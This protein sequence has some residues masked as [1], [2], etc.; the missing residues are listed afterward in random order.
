MGK[1]DTE[2]TGRRWKRPHSALLILSVSLQWP[3]L[4]ENSSKSVVLEQLRKPGPSDPV[5]GWFWRKR[6]GEDSPFPS[7]DPVPWACFQ[8]AL[9]LRKA[10][11]I[12]H[13]RHRLSHR[14]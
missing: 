5:L 12:H 3:L 4:K 7:E 2:V 14:L 13:H 1:V 8:E 11:Q 9:P 6:V 10:E